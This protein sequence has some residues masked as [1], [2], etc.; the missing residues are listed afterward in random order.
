M[1]AT[2]SSAHTGAVTED[3]PIITMHMAI[4]DRMSI[5]QPLSEFND[6]AMTALSCPASRLRV[7][8]RG[9]QI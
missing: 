6:P 1:G 7:P 5:H 8:K 2:I 4:V 3:N 9:R